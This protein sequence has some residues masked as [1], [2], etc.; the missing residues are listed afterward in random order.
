MSKYKDLID[1]VLIACNPPDDCNDPVVLKT[2][3]KACFDKASEKI[4][5]TEFSK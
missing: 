4:D 5:Q 3:M 2:Y 1:T